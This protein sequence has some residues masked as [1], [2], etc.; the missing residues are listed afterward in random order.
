MRPPMRAPP[1]GRPSSAL[2]RSGAAAP[3]SRSLR[4][5]SLALSRS[6]LAR[7]RESTSRSRCGRQACTY[8]S[9]PN[10]ATAAS[11]SWADPS[12][13]TKRRRSRRTPRPTMSRSSS[14][15][16]AD[17]SSGSLS[18]KRRPSTR[19]VPSVSTPTAPASGGGAVDR[20][21]VIL[22][23]RYPVADVRR[24]IPFDAAGQAQAAHDEEG[25]ELGDDLLEGVGRVVPA[26]A[27]FAPHPAAV[28]GP[29]DGFVRERGVVADRIVEAG[30]DRHPDSV[31][32]AIVG[33][34]IAP[35]HDLR[36][37]RPE[38]VLGDA[39]PD[40]RTGRGTLLIDPGRGQRAP[41]PPPRNHALS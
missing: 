16:A 26:A 5:A 6:S 40:S 39:D 4:S 3:S 41:W 28:A 33:R 24:V 32:G 22:Q 31:P 25:A 37:D 11:L 15:A 10:T 7:T 14:S 38:E 19:L 36:A 2:R 12:V 13:T 29:V 18:A 9:P 8:V 20:P 27:E 34:P 21:L 23:R 1:G 17:Q 35:R 30:E